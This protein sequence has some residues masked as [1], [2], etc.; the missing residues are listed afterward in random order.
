[1]DLEGYAGF[2]ASAQNTMTFPFCDRL[3]FFGVP[4]HP[5]N[6][7]LCRPD[8][9]SIEIPTRFLSWNL[10]GRLVGLLQFI[11]GTWLMYCIYAMTVD[12]ALGARAWV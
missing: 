3:T 6:A 1:L 9:D 2:L 7:D 11:T 12:L 4:V 5:R 8:I 10:G